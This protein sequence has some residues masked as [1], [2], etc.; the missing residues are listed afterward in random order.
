MAYDSS[1]AGFFKYRM[2]NDTYLTTV[3]TKKYGNID[4]MGWYNCRWGKWELTI[5]SQN[6]KTYVSSFNFYQ[7]ATPADS[8]LKYR[9]YAEM[10]EYLKNK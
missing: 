4:V 9:V 7:V 6:D 8:D 10:R 1:R 5:Y 2:K 3:C